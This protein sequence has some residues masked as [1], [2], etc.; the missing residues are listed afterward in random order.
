M[1]HS[2]MRGVWAEGARSTWSTID[3]SSAAAAAQPTEATPRP[4]QTLNASSTFFE[5]PT[6]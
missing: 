6:S 2:W 4:A 3:S 1:W 5:R